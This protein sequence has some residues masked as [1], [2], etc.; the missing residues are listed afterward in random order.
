MG[1]H[2]QHLHH[3][4]RLGYLQFAQV[5]CFCSFREKTISKSRLIPLILQLDFLVIMTSGVLP[6]WIELSLHRHCSQRL[7]WPRLIGACVCAN[8]YLVTLSS[9]SSANKSERQAGEQINE[10]FDTKSE[11]EWA[12]KQRLDCHSTSKLLFLYSQFPFL[13]WSC[14]F[15]EDSATGISSG[16]FFMM[17]LGGRRLCGKDRK[18]CEACY[19]HIRPGHQT[20][21]THKPRGCAQ[22][23]YTT[24]DHDH[25]QSHE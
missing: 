19:L 7:H 20:L 15:L 12:N 18:P 2:L 14:G 1:L 3:A 4:L 13:H 5:C 21:H 10:V 9:L 17:R 25:F 16:C 11:L 22:I 6:M 23:T 8:V 24:R